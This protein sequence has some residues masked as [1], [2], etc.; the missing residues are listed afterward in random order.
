LG[1]APQYLPL[2]FHPFLSSSQ[3]LFRESGWYNDDTIRI[4]D[5]EVTWVDRASAGLDRAV[6]F[7][8]PALVRT[9]RHDTSG[10]TGQRGFPELRDIPDRT[11]DHNAGQPTPLRRIV[12]NA[13]PYRIPQKSARVYNEDHPNWSPLDRVVKCEIVS[14]SRPHG[15]CRSNH[16]PAIEQG[17]DLCHSP[18]TVQFVAYNR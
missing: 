4:A 12:K 7:T 6:D 8:T 13:A 11:V 15:H 17:F 18:R 2:G 3:K 16:G 5:D 1:H 14:C 10:K 9:R